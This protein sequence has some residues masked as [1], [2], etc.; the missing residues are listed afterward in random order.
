MLTI[1]QMPHNARVWVYQAD[2]AFSEGESSFIKS[3]GEQFIS[4]WTAH[5]ASLKASFD[6]LHNRFIVISVDEQQAIA[7]GCSI[8]KSVHLMKELGSSFGLNFFDRL[9]IAYRGD[10]NIIQSCSLKDLELM[11]AQGKITKSTVVFNNTVTTKEAFDKEW[12]VPL[13]TTWLNRIFA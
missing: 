1:N 4:E 13:E 7:S 6:I 11:A 3:K 10:G 12:E 9:I 2:R 5:G 8:D